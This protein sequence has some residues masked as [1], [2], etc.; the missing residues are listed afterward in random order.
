MYHR[1]N[2]YIIALLISPLLILFISCSVEPEAYFMVERDEVIIGE[3]VKFY[4]FSQNADNYSWDFGD[5]SS[6]EE[7]D[8]KHTFTE[9]GSFIVT[10]TAT[11]SNGNRSTFKIEMTVVET[12]LLAVVVKEKDVGYF[13]SGA[14][15]SVYHSYDNWFNEV[16]PAAEGITDPDGY[17]EFNFLGPYNYYISVSGEGHNNRTLGLYN[18]NYVRTVTLD[19]DVFTVFTAM[20]EPD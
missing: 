2:K 9:T 7:T 3:Q 19:P 17:I 15:V 1:F 8:P 6:S 10:L 11:S 14:K 12:A 20:V 13:I 5:G 4:N 16:R 18:I